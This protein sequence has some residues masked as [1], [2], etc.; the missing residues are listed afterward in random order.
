[1][2]F[3]SLIF[4][5]LISLFTSSL[6]Q[7]VLDSNNE[8]DASKPTNFYTLLD[9]SL[10]YNS[11]DMGGNLIGYRAQLIYPPSQ[12]HLEGIQSLAFQIF[13]KQLCFL[14]MLHIKGKTT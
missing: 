8:I 6:A 1:M 14:Q 2:L 9:N 13:P 12:E 11:R 4:I 7:G 3:K 10:E 5:A